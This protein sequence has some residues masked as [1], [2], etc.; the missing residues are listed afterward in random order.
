LLPRGHDCFH[1]PDE[2]KTV[3]GLGS[4]NMMTEDNGCPYE[5][6][7]ERARQCYDPLLYQS[8]RCFPCRCQSPPNRLPRWTACKIIPLTQYDEEKPSRFVSRHVSPSQ[9]QKIIHWLQFRAC[10]EV[11]HI[12]Q[13]CMTD[14]K[15][16]H[17]WQF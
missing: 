9:H 3:V 1:N 12:G 8:H 2:Q 13:L 16:Q 10:D 4:R 17:L 7:W 15:T 11:L 14:A 6:C 5:S